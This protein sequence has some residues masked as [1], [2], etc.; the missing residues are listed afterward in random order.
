MNMAL[1]TKRKNE[2]NKER[3]G[4]RMVVVGREEGGVETERGSK[5]GENEGRG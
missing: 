5:D 1:S 2:E 4:S 3:G